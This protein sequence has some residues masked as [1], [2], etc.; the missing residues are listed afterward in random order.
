MIRLVYLAKKNSVRGNGLEP[1]RIISKIS[2]NKQISC[3]KSVK[4]YNQMLKQAYV[5]F[6]EQNLF[7]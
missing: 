7:T 2:D 3:S 5:S 6:F 4:P 1:S